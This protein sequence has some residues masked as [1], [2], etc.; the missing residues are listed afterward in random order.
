MDKN[1]NLKMVNYYKTITDFP[2]QTIPMAITSSVVSAVPQFFSIIIFLFW[3][4]G[5]GASFFAIKKLTGR[6]RF[7]HTITATSFLSFLA[8][9]SIAM[10]NTTT[11]K[12]INPYWIGFYIMATVGS[13]IMLKIYK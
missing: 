8:A 1:R 6:N 11:I 7:W 12:Y 3:I 2:N 4:F 13:W 9:L 5:S 10:M